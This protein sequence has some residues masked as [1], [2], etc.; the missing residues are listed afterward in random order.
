MENKMKRALISLSDKTGIVP[1]AKGLHELGI[2]ILS[3][4]G[5]AKLLKENLIPVVE[6]GDYTGQPE[7]LD[8]RLKTL[9]PKIH[10]GI[11]GMRSNVQHV[12]DMKKSQIQPIDLIVVNLY[13]F[14]QTI[15]QAG[16][17]LEHAIENIDIGGPTMIRAAAKNWQD[18]AVV[19]D[20][21]D[22]AKILEELRRGDIHD[23]PNV[24]KETKFELAKK[25]FVL[26]SR[27][28]GAI[29]N[30]LTGGKDNQ[31]PETFNFQFQKVQELRYGENPHQKAA[32]YKDGA[33][34]VSSAKQ[35]HGKELS[36]NNILDLDAAFGLVLDFSETACVIVKHTT[37]CGVAVGAI[38]ESPLHD[39]F[40]AARDCDPLSAF[41]GII[42]FNRPVDV[43]TAQEISKD[44]YECVIAPSFAPE[45]FQIIAGKKNIRIMELPSAISK[46]QL[47]LKRVSGGLLVQEKDEQI[48]NVRES[49]VV[50]ARQPSDTEWNVLQFA[51]K[52]C[53]GV[54]SNAIV[55]AGA[56]GNIIKTLGI[57]GG[58]VSRVDATK[59]GISKARTSLKGAV[60]ASDAFFPFRDNIDEA[61]KAGI[62]V[63]VQPGGSMR[64]DETIQAV[65]EH[66]MVML[67]TGA[68]HFRH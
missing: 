38:H 54:K 68:R 12:E 16:V 17:T 51:W 3:T 49:K 45:A 59:I 42:A 27:Y 35:L 19:V 64:D 30:Y 50:S 60:M 47:D 28:D 39:I 53:R 57:G 6:V 25:V 67:F 20:H 44:F 7:I 63:V 10:G 2:E 52:V 41:G 29:A 13:P 33:S 11:L 56:E 66:Q 14:E 22:Y 40:V 55:Y 61:A 18:V 32:F 43:A 31:F 37:P 9:H 1:F 21:Q 58:Q 36:F 26:T 46:K 4:G 24:T 34:G 65:N 5:T 23:A 48:E 15:A 62:A 8:G